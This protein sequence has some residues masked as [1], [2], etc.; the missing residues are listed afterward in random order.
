MFTRN[1]SEERFYY[2]KDKGKECY[3]ES[4]ERLYY[5]KD[6]GKGVGKNYYNVYDYKTNYDNLYDIDMYRCNNKN[7]SNNNY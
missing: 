7:N 3:N 1:K 4:E 5:G 6:K 2:G